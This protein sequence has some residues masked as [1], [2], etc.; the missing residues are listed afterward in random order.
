M[1]RLI[2]LTVALLLCACDTISGI[3]YSVDQGSFGDRAKAVMGAC[4]A[5]M[6]SHDFDGIRDKVELLKSPPDGPV[7][8][9]ILHRQCRADA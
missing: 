3:R 9:A 7:P 5:R 1:K 6:Q 4:T 8:F 2:V